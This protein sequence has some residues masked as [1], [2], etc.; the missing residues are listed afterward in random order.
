MSRCGKPPPRPQPGT[1]TALTKVPL[2]SGDAVSTA[3]LANYYTALGTAGALVGTVGSKGAVFPMA[4]TVA[5]QQALLEW[6][7]T[8][9]SES[10]APVLRGTAQCLEAGFGTTTTNAP[11]LQVEVTYTEE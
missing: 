7:W 11:T 8:Q 1:P 5:A 3:S 10:K 9:R 4:G 2:D 6:D